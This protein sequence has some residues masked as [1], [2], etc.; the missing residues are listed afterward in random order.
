MYGLVNKSIQDLIIARFGPR[1]WEEV[2]KGAGVDT[3]NFV[4]MQSYDD[5]L[6]YDLVASA[7]RVLA[8]P[9]ETLL[10]A[11]GEHWV[12]DTGRQGYGE[13]MNLAGKTFVEFLCELDNLHSRVAMIFP[14]LRPPQ[15]ECTDI[16]EN[17]LRLHYYSMRVGLSPMIFGLLRGLA[18]AFKVKDLQIQHIVRRDEGADH[19]EFA[20]QWKPE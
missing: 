20:L 9:P 12:E 13:I 8:L 4:S 1:A 10:E 7:S 15:F 6:T 16:T 2:R 3:D 18:Q 19:D 5:K 17:S 14:K 11:F